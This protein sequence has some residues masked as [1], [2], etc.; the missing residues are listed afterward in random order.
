V[1]LESAITCPICSATKSETMPTDA[2]QFFYECTSCGTL[3]RP[4]AGD[5]CVFCSYGSVACPPIQTAQD[6]G[7]SNSGSCCGADGVGIAPATPVLTRD[8][9]RLPLIPDWSMVAAPAAATAVNGIMAAGRYDARFGDLDARAADLLASVLV[10]YADRGAAPS[11]HDLG[12]A[13]GLPEH[14]LEQLLGELDQRDL[15]L[16]DKDRRSI[17]GAYPFTETITG[18]TVTFARTERTLSTMCVI[19]A[20]GAGAMCRDNSS[21]RSACHACHAPIRVETDQSGMR[22][23]EVTPSD[24]VVWTGFRQSV[25]C[26]AD[27]LCT[28]L[29]FFCC[30]EHLAAWRASGQTSEG[31]ELSAEEGFQVGKAL[32][33]DRALFGSNAWRRNEAATPE[34]QPIACTLAPDAL[35]DRVRWIKTLTAT[36]LRSFRREGSALHLTYAA[37]AAS[38][39]RELVRRE[40]SCC[41]FMQFDIKE[42]ANAVDLKISVPPDAV[43]SADSLLA[44]FLP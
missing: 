28:E 37:D 7:A 27:S 21:I 34:T 18:H 41:G 35:T 1:I 6:T 10:L 31:C 32:F 19:D 12:A 24:T 40:R 36:S 15:V 43:G 42:D 9:Q 38:E 3:L 17:R 39:V 33:A 26:A 5:C 2:C 44:H 29:V 23:A 11:L 16:W 13:T 14:H 20:L 25:Q 8:R 4:K 30:P 22:L